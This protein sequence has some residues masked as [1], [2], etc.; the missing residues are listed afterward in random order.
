MYILKNIVY[1]VPSEKMEFSGN[2][3]IEQKIFFCGYAFFFLGVDNTHSLWL[4][5]TC[6]VSGCG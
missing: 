5:Y 3:K 1:V 6:A 4:F 2:D